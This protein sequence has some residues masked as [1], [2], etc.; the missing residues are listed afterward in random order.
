M[1][2]SLDVKLN[3]NKKYCALYNEKYICNEVAES[4][5]TIAG[6]ILGGKCHVYQEG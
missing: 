6:R 5:H 1:I 2:V 4:L 3:P